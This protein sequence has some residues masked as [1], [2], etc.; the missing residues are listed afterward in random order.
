M[1]TSVLIPLATIVAAIVG[2][3]VTYLIARRGSS[4]RVETSEAST[5]WEESRAIRKELQEES[6]SLRLRLAEAETKLAEALTKLAEANTSL[7]N[8][9][10][11]AERLREEVLEL[12]RICGKTNDDV[13]VVA[14]EIQVMRSENRN[15]Q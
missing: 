7:V 13:A 4:G 15:G 1:P 5:L 10:W 12:R 8:A 6:A 11:Q 3:L 9:K 14:R 2:G